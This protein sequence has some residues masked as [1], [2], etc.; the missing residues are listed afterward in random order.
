[1]IIYN[2]INFYKN[3]MNWSIYPCDAFTAAK[4]CLHPSF[5]ELILD[6][7][8]VFSKSY[9]AKRRRTNF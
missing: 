3:V 8:N 5:Y 2:F 9:V 6:I 1:M 7:Y 4:D